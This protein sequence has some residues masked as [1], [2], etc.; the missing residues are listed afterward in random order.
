MIKKII[1]IVLIILPIAFLTFLIPGLVY[2]ATDHVVISEIQIAGTTADDEF[3]EL[4]NPTLSDIVIDG[5][6]LTKKTDS[7]TESNLVSGLTGTIPAGG[8]F[9]IA[10][11]DTTYDGVVAADLYY[12]APSNKLASDNTVVLYSDAGSAVIDKVG[13]GTATDFEIAAAAVPAADG[14]IERLPVNEDTNNNSLDFSPRA[15][16]DPQNSGASP[17]P[18][19]SPTPEPT[20][21]PS[22]TATPAPTFTPS[23]TAGHIVISEIQIAGVSANDDFVELYNPTATDYDLNGHK[24]VKRTETGTADTSLK[25][26]SS[27]AIIPA[28]GH[29]LWANSGWTPPVNADAATT[30][31]LASNNGVALRNGALDAGEIIDSVGWG[32]ASNVFVETAVFS[33]NPPAGSSL[34]RVGDDTDNNSL[35]FILREFSDPQCSGLLPSPSPTPIPTETPLPTATPTSAPTLTPSP[36]PTPTITPYPTTRTVIGIFPF[37]LNPKVCYLE[38][39]VF[40]FGFMRLTFPKIVCLNL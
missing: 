35:D 26:W 36:A 15:L 7:G 17:T 12:S 28:G 5:W 23:P 20:E 3:V 34:E 9:L 31:T 19:P 37:S 14:S 25:S 2:S 29:Y 39:R 18:T 8:Y 11:S 16:S 24:L 4:Y 32:T 21:S 38:Y 33:Q 6:R 10:H 30:G 22:P 27:E 1:S 13:M 40:R